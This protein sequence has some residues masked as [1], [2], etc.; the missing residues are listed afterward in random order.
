[1][2]RYK[3]YVI[4]LVNEIEGTKTLEARE[5]IEATYPR[6][7]YQE[8]EHGVFIYQSVHPSRSVLIPWVNITHVR[9][10]QEEK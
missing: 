10:T 9:F 6:K 4:H 7:V 3:V 2:S 5:E 8:T 1:M